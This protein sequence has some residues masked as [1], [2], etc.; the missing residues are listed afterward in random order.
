[1][2]NLQVLDITNGFNFRDLGGYRTQDGRTLASHRLIRSAS[3]DYLTDPELTYLSDY[4][5]RHI[6]DFRSTQEQEASPDRI[7]GGA[8]YLFDPVFSVDETLTSQSPES[9]AANFSADPDDGRKHMKQTYVDLVR[10]D[11]AQ[12]AYRKFFDVLLNHTASASTSVLFHCTVGKD[13]TG[14]GAVYVL[15]V[16]GVDAATIRADYLATNNFMQIPKHFMLGKVRE[17]GGNLNLEKNLTDLL[18]ASESY[19]DSALHTINTDFGGMQEYLRGPLEL[20]D[21]QQEELRALYL[22]SEK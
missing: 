17:G 14:M 4:G 7:P 10:Q 22:T 20:D 12:Q 8:E 9:L 3:L 1:M 21:E 18:T 5:V 15:S 19:L 16:L 13:R 11:S 2:S 6:V